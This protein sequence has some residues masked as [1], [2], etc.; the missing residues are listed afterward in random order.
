MEAPDFNYN[1]PAPNPQQPNNGTTD[2]SPVATPAVIESASASTAC[3]TS[4]SKFAYILTGSVLGILT[5]LALALTL[6]IFSITRTAVDSYESSSWDTEHFDYPD[7]HDYDD[8]FDYD[9]YYE[10][11]LDEFEEKLIDSLTEESHVRV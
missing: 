5:L 2:L 11:E 7:G 6:L 10:D 8:D 9:D 3:Q 4:S 1:N